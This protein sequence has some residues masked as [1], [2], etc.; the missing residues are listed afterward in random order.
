VDKRVAVLLISGS[1]LASI[2]IFLYKSDF[3]VPAKVEI[4]EPSEVTQ[5]DR[6]AKINEIVCEIAGSVVNPGVYR[7]PLGSRVS[8]LLIASGGLS[9]LADREFVS[10]TINQAAKLADGQ[11]IY[12]PQR[13][14]VL[15]ATVGN[16]KTQVLN[17]ESDKVNINIASLSEL[18]HL[19][20]IGLIYAQKIVE[21]RPYSE[22]GELV[23]RKILPNNVFEK[24]KDKITVY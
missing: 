3:F 4:I 16:V 20:G 24:I 10:R 9:S 12:I 21:Q 19:P 17:V 23:S 11:K 15:S 8:D 14:E 2:G 13:S 5:Q 7:L 1:I 18:D 6:G 22:V